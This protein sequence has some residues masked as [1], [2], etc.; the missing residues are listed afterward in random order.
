MCVASLQ[1]RGLLN[2]KIQFWWK[3]V[4]MRTIQFFWDV[5]TCVL[6]SD[7]QTVNSISDDWMIVVPPSSGTRIPSCCAL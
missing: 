1:E 3:Q 2:L 6:V 7:Y 5:A 4:V